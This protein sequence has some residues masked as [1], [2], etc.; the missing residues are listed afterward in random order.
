[1]NECLIHGVDGDWC[2]QE[3]S[4]ALAAARRSHR[5]DEHAVEH[6]GEPRPNGQLDLTTICGVCGR[7]LGSTR[8]NVL[9]QP[10]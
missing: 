10:K 9:R 5:C 2:T 8:D 4:D 1:M 6:G 3:C 7:T